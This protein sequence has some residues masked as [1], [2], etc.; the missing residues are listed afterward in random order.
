MSSGLNISVEW[1]SAN[2]GLAEIKE[3]SGL[4]SIQLGD[5]I[6][7]R[8]EDEWSKSIR[9]NVR[10]SAYPLAL[11]FA[12]SW[13]RLRWEPA[14]E[15]SRFDFA[16]RMAH[17][18]SA[19]GF[20]Y[21]W[22]RLVFASDGENIDIVS[23]PSAPSPGEP[24]RYLESFRGVISSNE[25]E[26]GLDD[27]INLVLARLDLLRIRDT[28]LQRL[29]EEITEERK[30]P[31]A[32]SHRR[33]EARLGFEPDEAPSELIGQLVGLAA[34]AGEDSVSEI[35]PA[36]AGTNPKA[37]LDAI[38]GAAA[39]DAP[40]GR[41]KRPSKLK[42]TAYASALPWERGRQAAR[43]VR[44]AYSITSDALSNADVSEL[45]GISQEK[46]HSEEGF[47]H[48]P[49]GLVVRNGKPDLVKYVF[50][51]KG[52]NARR[53]EAARFLAESLLAPQDDRWLP[54][55]DAKTARQKFQRAFA[56]EFL[57]PIEELIKFLGTD[58]SSEAITEAGE[59][60]QV[61]SLAVSSHLA[62]NGY[63]H[64]LEVEALGIQH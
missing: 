53:F 23:I 48:L 34:I 3:T 16:W 50:R 37:R 30:D 41:I 12:S 49:L 52:Q 45:L 22:P 58:Y 28:D 54:T 60:F 19:A 43:E 38:I 42:S 2:S 36:C 15:R 8:S 51:R 6:A 27:F 17:E 32:A 25:F 63:I 14:F 26:R 4:L 18:S 55:T 44:R 39:S 57:C 31:E 21:I 35:A 29:W 40:E 20:G 62:N 64:P 9:S 61:A 13:W 10:L 5:L 1:L 7:T 59:H 11:W 33:L 46:L 56:A 24:I 47:Q